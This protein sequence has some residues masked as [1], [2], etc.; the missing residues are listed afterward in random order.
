MDL[1]LELLRE[2]LLELLLYVFYHVIIR[3]RFEILSCNYLSIDPY[4]FNT[5]HM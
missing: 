3:G 1:L 2:L 5:K 4:F